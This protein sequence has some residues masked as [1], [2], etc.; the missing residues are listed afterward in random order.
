MGKNLD[1]SS[2]K[3][4]RGKYNNEIPLLI[5]MTKTPNYDPTKCKA[6]E[7]E[8]SVTAGRKAKWYNHFERQ[9]GSFL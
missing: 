4:Y 5:R 7:Q 3:T 1:A 2:K 8:L 6:I 9:L